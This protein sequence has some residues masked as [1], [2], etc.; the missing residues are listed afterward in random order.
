MCQKQKPEAMDS[1]QHQPVSMP[2]AIIKLNYL[3]LL[4]SAN[5]L[6]KLLPRLLSVYP[7]WVAFS[8]SLSLSPSGPSEMGRVFVKRGQESGGSNS[9][10]SR[11]QLLSSAQSPISMAIKVDAAR[12]TN[13]RCFQYFAFFFRKKKMPKSSLPLRI[14]M[15]LDETRI[16]YKIL[17]YA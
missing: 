1:N 4:S 9:A 8:S 11:K 6:I 2:L 5:S 7:S 13:E 12:I 16:H 10:G 3:F 17:N 15:L 14:S